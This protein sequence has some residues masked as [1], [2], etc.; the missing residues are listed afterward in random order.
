MSDV[1]TLHQNVHKAWHNFLLSLSGMRDEFMLREK[2]IGLWS[3][4]DVM[5]HITSWEEI[6]IEA[7]GQLLAGEV[8]QVFAIDWDKE[9][10]AINAELVAERADLSLRE[11]WRNLG[12]T[13]RILARAISTPAVLAEPDM[14]SLAHEITWKHYEHHGNRIRAYRKDKCP[15]EG[16]VYYVMKMDGLPDIANPEHWKELEGSQEYIQCALEP[17]A[18]VYMANRLYGAYDGGLVVLVI[19]LARF[20]PEAV[21]AKGRTTLS[22]HVHGWFNLEAVL[23]VRQMFRDG[24]GNWFFPWI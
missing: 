1:D 13:H 3:I 19:D 7:A 15:R 4:K 12:A 20:Q 11:S 18:A 22:S 16:L 5:G 17:S 24:E 8:P 21:K 10:D 2:T 9:G 23:D 6:Y 14:V